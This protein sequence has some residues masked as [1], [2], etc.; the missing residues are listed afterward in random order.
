MKNTIQFTYNK[1]FAYISMLLL[2]LLILV[3]I[4]RSYQLHD[5]EQIEILR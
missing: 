1:W 5:P 4:T 3:F 2:S